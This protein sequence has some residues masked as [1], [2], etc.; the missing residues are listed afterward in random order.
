MVFAAAR[1]NK[2]AADAKHSL[3]L[4][5]VMAVGVGNALEFY[6][7]LTY[8]FFAIQIGRCFFPSTHRSQGLLLSLATFGVGFLSRPLGAVVIGRIGDRIGRKPAMLISFAVMGG[9]I[10]VLALIPPY[11]Q[12]GV[13]APVLLVL[14]RLAQGFALG[15]EVGPSTAYLVE[16]APPHRRGLYVSYQFMTQDLAILGAGIVGY[17]LSNA[18]S[19]ASL[20]AWGWRVAFLLGAAVVPV[21]LLARRT[22]PETLHQAEPS[23]SAARVTPRLTILSLL[24]LASTSTYLFGIDYI[25][26][27]SQ[28]SLHLKPVVAFGTTVILGVF[29]AGADPLSGLLSDRV[30]RRPVMLAAAGVLIL[31][32]IPLFSA[33]IHGKSIILVYV[34]TAILATLQGFFTAP[35]LIAITEGLPKPVRSGVLGTLYALSTSIF[36]GSTQL[37]IKA[38][39][40]TT[41]SAMA[42]AWYLTGAIVVG[43][44]AMTFL[45]ETAPARLTRRP[46]TPPT[47]NL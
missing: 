25:T 30:G 9:S 20:D 16:A 42:P 8:A 1:G 14:C 7:F 40:E 6:D 19:P 29:A 4:R 13:A 22:L 17:C 18:L 15:G 45:G 47:A 5:H 43:A 32:L 44:A 39:I 2:D 21:G 46:R 33:M 3:A 38:L 31:L 27:Y 23:G 28:D 11:A 36:G 12:I 35:A 26:T 41:R 10:I 24:V 37:V 34:V